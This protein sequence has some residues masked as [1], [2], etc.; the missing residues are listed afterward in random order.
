[1]QNHMQ[2]KRRLLW[3][4]MLV[5]LVG[6]CQSLFQPAAVTRAQQQLETISLSSGTWLVGETNS[7]LQ[8]SRDGGATWHDA[9]AVNPLWG[10]YAT[11]PGTQYVNWAPDI[12]A[13]EENR[14]V[15]YRT[16]F[17]LP[18]RFQAPSLTVQVHADNVATIFLNGTQIGMQEFAETPGNFNDPAES[19]ETTDA[20]HFRAGTN[21]LEFDIYNF[22]GPSAFSYLVT[23]SYGY[24]PTPAYLPV[25]I[26]IKPGNA[27]NCFKN[28]GKGVLPVAILSSADG[29]DA[30]TVD[31]R[32]VTLQGMF[33]KT[34]GKEGKLL[35]S[36]E[37]VNSDGRLDLLVHIQDSKEAFPPGTTTATLRGFLFDGTSI[38]GSD[39]ICLISR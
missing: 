30:T 8:F 26:D 22:T 28:N 35:A 37:D 1:M 15:R 18:A 27:Q 16:T 5:L 11:I 38:E 19:F 32:S 24:E 10:Y 34:V 3:T 7:A 25:S 21:I 31:P 2:G 23:I 20:A 36:R 4:T 12:Y 6:V 29:F 33:V 13:T 14:S 17:D 39:S 9:Y